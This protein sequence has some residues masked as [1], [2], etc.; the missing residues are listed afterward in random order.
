MKK[1]LSNF[2]RKH[3]TKSRGTIELTDP[4]VSDPDIELK[5]L[6]PQ[7]IPIYVAEGMQD[8]GITGSDWIQ[9]TGAEVEK[10][11]D[12]E[13]G[14]VRI[15]AAIPKSMPYEFCQFAF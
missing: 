9:E 7:E 8:I 15:V 5:I 11:Q 1:Q 13:Y 12:L 3:N 2:F 4:V 14:R 10:L 6:R